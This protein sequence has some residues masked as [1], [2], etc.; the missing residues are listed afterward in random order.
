[1]P[2]SAEWRHHFEAN[3]RTLLEIPWAKGPELNAGA[4]GALGHSVAEF[5]RGESSEGRHLVRYAAAYAEASGD[6]DYVPAIRLFIAEEQRHAGDLARFLTI[7]NLPLARKSFADGVFRRLRNLVG[8]L[9]VSIAVLILAEIIAQVYYQALQRAT[10]SQILGRLCEQI[11]RDEGS[12][13]QFQAEQLGR[14]RARR[15]DM[16]YAATMLGQRVLFCGTCA[17]VW[18]FHA[19]AFRW[20]EHGLAGFWRSA[21]LHFDRAF[22]VSNGARKA[23]RED[24]AAK[25]AMRAI[26]SRAGE[27]GLRSLPST[28]RDS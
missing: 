21:W 1:M 16:L 28:P 9:E 15:R 25:A 19:R 6:S 7:N 17:V 10:D 23:C 20:G 27:P 24:S 4:R 13:V 22:A 5:Q 14:L 2:T 26:S 12:H 18:L 3:Q 11:L 8:T